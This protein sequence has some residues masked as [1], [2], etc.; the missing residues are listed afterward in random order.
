VVEAWHRIEDMPDGNNWS[1]GSK[2]W[3]LINSDRPVLIEAGRNSVMTELIK[4]ISVPC[5][6]TVVNY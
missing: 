3:G 6:F 5:N 1:E 2:G 4:E